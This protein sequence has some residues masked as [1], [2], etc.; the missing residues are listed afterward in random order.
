MIRKAVDLILSRFVIT[1]MAVLV[2]DVLWQVTS[3]YIMKEPS[4]W[5]DE[6][7][8]FLLIWVGLFGAAYATGKK[9]HLAIDLLPRKLNPSRRKYLYLLINGLIGAFAL[10]V[11]IIGGV[12]LVYISFKL[13]QISSA[14]E[15]PVGYVYLVLPVSGLFILFYAVHDMIFNKMPEVSL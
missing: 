6:L 13:N 3:R 15:I 7:A 8:G 1:V 4:S 12:R 5:T 11:L 2:L 10:I 14:L 9:D